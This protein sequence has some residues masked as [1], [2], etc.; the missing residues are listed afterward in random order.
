[1]KVEKISSKMFLDLIKEEALKIKQELEQELNEGD[2]TKVGDPV[3]DVK[4]NK[5]DGTGDKDAALVH[6]SKSKTEYKKGPAKTVKSG[7]TDEG[8]PVED[9]D[10][11]QQPS[12]GGSDEKAATAVGVKAG[13]AKGGND[14]TTGQHKA[15]FESKTDGPKDSVSDPFTKKASEKMNTND[16]VVDEGTKTFVE[17]G[18]EKG[19]TDVTAGQHKAGWKESAPKSD[20]DKRIADGIQLKET[21]SKTELA[22]LIMSEA[23]KL[24]KKQMLE[25][26]LQKLKSQIA[27]L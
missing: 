27:N 14:V 15:N 26:E 13:A 9:V 4:L 19:G 5:N 20:N 11:N 25:Q 2:I 7:T 3:E 6:K 23:K 17:A 21:Y 1:M 24:A 18:A 22:Q 12:K 16:K 10:L 8:D